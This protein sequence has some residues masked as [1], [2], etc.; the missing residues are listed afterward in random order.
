MS[1]ASVVNV[2]I[3]AADVTLKGAARGAEMR[4]RVGG[5]ESLSREWRGAGG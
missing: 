1:R 3:W 2:E 5:V 4:G